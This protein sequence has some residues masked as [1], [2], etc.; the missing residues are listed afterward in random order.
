MPRR[1]F[2]DPSPAPRRPPSACSGKKGGPRSGLLCAPKEVP[3]GC[4]ELAAELEESLRAARIA[5][6]ES[7]R[8]SLRQA[9]YKVVL[10]SKECWLRQAALLR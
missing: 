9:R 1:D 2:S 7:T 10:A 8:A 3:A 4:A 6:A 5:A